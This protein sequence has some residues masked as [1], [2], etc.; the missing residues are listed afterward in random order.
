MNKRGA[1]VFLI[2]PEDIGELYHCRSCY[3][4]IPFEER[5]HTFAGRDFRNSSS[6]SATLALLFK[7]AKPVHLKK[8]TLPRANTY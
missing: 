4:F 7:E 8:Q 5:F 6:G 2:H 3:W 1:V